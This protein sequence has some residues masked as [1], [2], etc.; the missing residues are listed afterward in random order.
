MPRE[1]TG[2]TD[3]GLLLHT[4]LSSRLKVL[5]G[6]IGV[7]ILGAGYL[8]V[9]MVTPSSEFADLHRADS[10]QIARTQAVVDRV[11]SLELSRDSISQ[12]M[13]ILV[14]A[15]CIDRTPRELELMQLRC[16]P[17]LRGSVSHHSRP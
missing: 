3:A 6:M 2:E 11:Y 13:K 5:Y 12:M 7:L 9:H 16:D 8:G 4:L 1:Q 15:Q 14:S 10:I 17:A